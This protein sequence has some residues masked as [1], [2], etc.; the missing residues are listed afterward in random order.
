MFSTSLSLYSCNTPSWHFRIVVSISL[1]CEL[2]CL[3]GNGGYCLS[4]LSQIEEAEEGLKNI[5][6]AWSTSLMRR[7]ESLRNFSKILR[8]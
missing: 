4:A 3:V 1:F 2:F 6:T 5:K 7:I 8:I